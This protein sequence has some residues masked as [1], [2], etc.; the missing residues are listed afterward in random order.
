MVGFE[1]ITSEVQRL[2]GGV[3]RDVVA[4]QIQIHRRQVLQRRCQS[5]EVAVVL[6]RSR[7]EYFDRFSQCRFRLLEAVHGALVV[8]EVAQGSPQG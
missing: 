1:Q 4:A 8:A 6:G 3:D 5:I 7:P 2:L